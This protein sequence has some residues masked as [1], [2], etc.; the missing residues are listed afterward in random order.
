MI[1]NYSV[2]AF[3]DI[4]Q[5]DSNGKLRKV[6]IIHD[7]FCFDLDQNGKRTNYGQRFINSESFW[8]QFGPVIIKKTDRPLNGFEPIVWGVYWTLHVLGTIIAVVAV[9]DSQKIVY[10]LISA[11]VFAFTVKYRYNK[12]IVYLMASI[13]IIFVIFLWKYK[14]NKK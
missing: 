11:H 2:N 10:F 3:Y 14:P 7:N 9:P 4:F 1:T 12:I 8:S 6:A 13:A 5:K